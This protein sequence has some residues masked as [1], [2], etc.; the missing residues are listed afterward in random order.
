MVLLIAHYSI[1]CVSACREGVRHPDTDHLVIWLAGP[2]RY[3]F[4]MGHPTDLQSESLWNWNMVMQD[5]SRLPVWRWLTFSWL[6][7]NLTLSHCLFFSLTQKGLYR[8]H[9]HLTVRLKIQTGIP[10]WKMTNV[11]QKLAYLFCQQSNF[12]AVTRHYI[13]DTPVR[14]HQECRSIKC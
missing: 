11:Q 6:V 13:T 4:Q 12:A 1:T 3:H 10:T 7:L 14:I 5:K 8:N 9:T 2:W